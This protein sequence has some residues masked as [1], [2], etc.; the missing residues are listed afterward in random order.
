MYKY[1]K[2]VADIISRNNYDIIHDNNKYFA[3]LSLWTAKKKRIPIRISHVHVVVP[4]K[5]NIFH[6]A[7]IKIS[8]G[9]S[10]YCANVRMACSEEAGK[11]M[12]GNKKFVVL[13]NAI[14]PLDYK[15]DNTVRDKFRKEY[16]CE[17]NFVLMMVARKDSLKRFDFAF[18]VFDKLYRLNKNAKLI[19][20]GLSDEEC[21]GRDRQSYLAMSEEARSKVYFFGRRRDAN[22]LLN[23]ADSF[24]MTSEHEGFGISIIEAQANGLPCFVSDAIPYSVA[25]T[26]LVT[27][28][29]TVTSSDLW[30]E[31]INNVVCSNDR[32]RYFF[33]IEGGKYNVANV[34]SLLREVYE[35]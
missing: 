29:P 6:N 3:F 11:S 8:S 35:I 5:R 7:F 12:Y 33:E 19:L 18:K 13:N 32:E 28:L 23:M 24:I 2:E 17:N 4:S 34:V 14:N 30:A 15:Y 31:K 9:L 20:V 21:T 1:Y 22:K 27:F 25:A 16:S 10:S 26:E